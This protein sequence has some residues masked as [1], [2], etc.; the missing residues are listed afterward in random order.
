MSAAGPS[1]RIN[2]IGILVL[3]AAVAILVFEVWG[4]RVS[5]AQ[6]H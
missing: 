6:L 4:I 1:A 2:W 5:L 3:I